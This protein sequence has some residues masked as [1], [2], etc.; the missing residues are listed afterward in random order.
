MMEMVY[1]YKIDT[2]EERELKEKFSKLVNGELKLL[3]ELEYS[4][5]K[6]REYFEELELKKIESINSIFFAGLTIVTLVLVFI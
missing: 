1:E 4:E 3:K 2:L 5:K 6:K